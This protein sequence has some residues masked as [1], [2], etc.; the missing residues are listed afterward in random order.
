[1]ATAAILTY[2]DF[3][4][5]AVSC[6]GNHDNRIYN[7]WWSEQHHGIKEVRVINALIRAN[8]RFDMLFLPG[9]R[10]GFGDMNEYFF[11]KMAD[12]YCEWLMG[13]SRRS[14]VDIKEMNND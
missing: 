9:Q 4:K 11:W 2:P 13:D 14:E 7:R 12:Y 1:M 8:K 10:H 3:F 5:V 6:S